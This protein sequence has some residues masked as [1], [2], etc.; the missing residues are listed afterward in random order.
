[1]GRVDTKVIKDGQNM[2]KLYLDRQEDFVCEVSVKNASLKDS[3][4][5]LIV[6]SMDGPSLVFNGKLIGEKCVIPVK[7]LKG[8]LDENSHGKMHLEVIVEDTYFKPWESDFIVEEHTS[9]KVK[10]NESIQQISKPIVKVRMPPKIQKPN[11]N[12]RTPICEISMI[13]ERFEIKRKNLQKRKNDFVHI[14][15]EYLKANPE[16]N[17]HTSKILSG[18]LISLK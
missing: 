2:Y 9:V 10:V 13:C 7:R 11:S 1:M 6:E 5:R 15:K 14:I 4:A 3:I 18:I 12:I 17:N 16:Y 8:I